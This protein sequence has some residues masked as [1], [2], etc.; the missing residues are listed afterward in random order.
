MRCSPRHMTLQD[1]IAIHPSAGFETDFPSHMS[2][3][4][5]RI[6]G[7]IPHQGP[8]GGDARPL[9]APVTSLTP[10]GRSPPRTAPS[11]QLPTSPSTVYPWLCACVCVCVSLCACALVAHTRNDLA[12]NRSLTHP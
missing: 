6:S 12:Y 2:M 8:M 3:Q 5:L 10:V 9:A 1:T 7:T 11:C 4:G